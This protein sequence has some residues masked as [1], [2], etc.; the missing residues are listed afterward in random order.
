MEK[1]FFSTDNY[2]HVIGVPYFYKLYR[3]KQIS[4]SDIPER[5]L[6]RAF[7]GKHIF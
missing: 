6:G 2:S 7:K 5:R 3:L 1:L 4:K